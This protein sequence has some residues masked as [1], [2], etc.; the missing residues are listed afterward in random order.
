MFHLG[1]T[2]NSFPFRSSV[3]EVHLLKKIGCKETRNNCGTVSLII[4][5]AEFNYIISIS[6]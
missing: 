1:R 5:F 4:T 6:L 3:K 2:Q